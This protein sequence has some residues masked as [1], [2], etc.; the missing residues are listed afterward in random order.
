VYEDKEINKYVD[1]TFR[2][3][4]NLIEIINDKIDEENREKIL[5]HDGYVSIIFKVYTKILKANNND[6]NKKV[7]EPYFSILS[8]LLKTDKNLINKL[9]TSGE[10]P[11]QKSADLLAS[12]INSKLPEGVNTL[13]VKKGGGLETPILEEIGNMLSKITTINLKTENGQSQPLIKPTGMWLEGAIKLNKPVTNY[14]DFL[15]NV[16]N[17]LYQILYEGGKNIPEEFRKDSV[18]TRINAFRTWAFHDVRHGDL[19]DSEKKR[20]SAENAVEYY[21]S[22]RAGPQELNAQQLE[23]LKN[24]LLEDVYEFL[25][26]LYN[27]YSNS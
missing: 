10:G 26:K 3:V 2:L 8:E 16:I 18:L 17:V 13:S 20:K 27:K 7:L 4:K 23:D 12:M 15:N 6:V 1:M 5:K 14:N 21:I 25:N 24:K 19:K 22:I 9:E 11:R